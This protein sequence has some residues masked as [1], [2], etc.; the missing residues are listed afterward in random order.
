MSNY[1]A[2]LLEIVRSHDNPE[3]ALL[4]AIE[5]IASFLEQSVSYQVPFADS[6]QALG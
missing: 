6:P 5:I 1:K 3:Q 2:E 4:T